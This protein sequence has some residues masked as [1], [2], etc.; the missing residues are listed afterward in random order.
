VRSA[1]FRAAGAVDTTAH[2]SVAEIV[3]TGV[4]TAQH[5]AGSC[6]MAPDGVVGPDLAV[7]GVEGLS[8]ADASI[9]PDN[10]MNNINLTCF[11]IG[12]VAADHVLGRVT[13]VAAP[14]SAS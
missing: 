8:V 4:G 5:P 1:P 9:F 11:V 14:A 6:R 2:L 10:L 3:A 12:E 13:P 7:H